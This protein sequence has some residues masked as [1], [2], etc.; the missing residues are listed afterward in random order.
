MVTYRNKL[1]LSLFDKQFRKR[2]HLYIQARRFLSHL[3]TKNTKLFL[4]EEDLEFV[5]KITSKFLQ[6]TSTWYRL[7]IPTNIDLVS[8]GIDQQTNIGIDLEL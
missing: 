7:G 5:D 3:R 1:S 6:K 8:T 2:H 4:L